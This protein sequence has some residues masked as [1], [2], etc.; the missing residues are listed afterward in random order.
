[1]A[2]APP[3]YTYSSEDAPE[4]ERWLAKWSGLPMIFQ[5]RTRE[6][7]VAAGAAFWASEQTKEENRRLAVAARA[8]KRREAG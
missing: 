1:M 7:V 6:D 3:L 8:E 5:G 2:A 4:R